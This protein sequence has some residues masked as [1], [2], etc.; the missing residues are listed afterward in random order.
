MHQLIRKTPKM[1]QECDRLHQAAGHRENCGQAAALAY[2]NNIQT[3]EGAC[4]L[5]GRSPLGACGLG[6]SQIHIMI[7]IFCIL[8]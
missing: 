4:W 5:H 8:G 2:P 7:D 6:A 1:K 3:D